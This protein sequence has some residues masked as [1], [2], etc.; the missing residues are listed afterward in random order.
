MGVKGRQLKPPRLRLK[1]RTYFR[2]NLRTME[3][4]ASAPVTTLLAGGPRTNSVP[5]LTPGPMPVGEQARRRRTLGCFTTAWQAPCLATASPRLRSG[6]V[7]HKMTFIR[8]CCRQAKT[9]RRFKYGLTWSPGPASLGCTSVTFRHV[10]G[11]PSASRRHHGCS[12]E[13][14]RCAHQVTP[15]PA[16][17]GREGSR[18]VDRAA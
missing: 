4:S 10:E 1:N 5:A 14:P 8:A 2:V 7:F 6:T 18:G 9:L 17:L 12:A 11:G 3:A 16:R 15:P 13:S